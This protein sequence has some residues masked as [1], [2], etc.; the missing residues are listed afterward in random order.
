V[1]KSLNDTLSHHGLSQNVVRDSSV[2]KINNA[3]WATRP[4]TSQMV[5]WASGD[6]QCMFELYKCQL[7]TASPH[8]KQLGDQMSQDF[9]SG[10]RSSKCSMVTAMNPGK[11]VGK[12]G[13]NIR[14]LQSSTSAHIC[15]F[16]DRQK[17]MFIVYY[18]FDKALEKVQRAAWS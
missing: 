4:L 8:V 10:V 3:F 11:F 12:G 9:L 7:E 14:Q 17:G 6:V 5:E 15:G 1:D 16:G 13:A 18:K 2:Y